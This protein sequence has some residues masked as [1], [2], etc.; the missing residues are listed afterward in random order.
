MKAIGICGSPRTGSNTEILLREVLKTMKKSW[1]E[2]E[3]ILLR[4]KNIELCRGC[5]EKCSKTGECVIS[6]DM[7]EI[8]EKLINSDVIIFGSPTYFD[9]VTGL[10]KNFMD[11]TDPLTVNKKLKNKIAGVI[12]VGLVGPESIRKNMRS[13]MDFCVSHRMIIKGGV[14]VKAYEENEISRKENILI[15]ARKLGKKLLK[16]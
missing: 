8:Y 11:R 13:L 1:V 3:L 5:D 9:N 14:M 12:G 2:T 7:Q 4:E 10:M 16:V 15:E 6:D